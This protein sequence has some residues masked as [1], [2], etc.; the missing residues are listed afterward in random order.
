MS[1]STYLNKCFTNYINKEEIKIIF[2]LGS[3]D[4]LDALELKKYYNKSKIYSFECNPDSIIECEKNLINN[5]DITLIKKA[6]S[7]ENTNVDFYPFDRTKYDNIGASSMYLIDFTKRNKNDPDYNRENPQYKIT[8][9]GIRLDKYMN[10][11]SINNIDLLCMDLQEY[12]LNALKSL[13]NKLNNVKYIITECSINNTYINGTYFKELN[14]FLIK[15]NFIYISNDYGD[16]N[17]IL[18]NVRDNYIFI[19]LL[20]KNKNL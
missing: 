18:N 9:E 6:V 10:E 19:N 20:Y 13:G 15:N 1:N 5:N 17:Y 11:N 16:I 14:D 8:V 4:L 12:E 7:I 2:E 3:R